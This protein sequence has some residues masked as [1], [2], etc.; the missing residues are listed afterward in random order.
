[1]NT[2]DGR[3]RAA[4]EERNV[5]AEEERADKF[6]AEVQKVIIMSGLGFFLVSAAVCFLFGS[7]VSRPAVNAWEDASLAAEQRAVIEQQR[8]TLDSMGGVIGEVHAE[9]GAA[10]ADFERAWAEALD[11]RSQFAAIDAFVRTVIAA[12]R[13][14]EGLQRADSGTDAGEG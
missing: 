13:E 2:V 8:R 7:C 1:M 10:R 11:L 5:T 3:H 4:E 12:E 14:L 9:L 6:W